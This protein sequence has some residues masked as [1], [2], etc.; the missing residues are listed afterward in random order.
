MAAEL[1]GS[2]CGAH[3]VVAGDFAVQPRAAAGVAHERF[4]YARFPNEGTQEVRAEG[5]AEALPVYEA[6][7]IRVGKALHP[8]TL[9][10]R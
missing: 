6:L 5:R 10:S 3:G 2:R 1:A 4:S 8:R 9:A 7:K